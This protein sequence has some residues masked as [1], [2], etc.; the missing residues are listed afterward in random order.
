MHQTS[1]EVIADLLKSSVSAKFRQDLAQ[2]VRC[3]RLLSHTELWQR[4]NDHCNSVANLVL[5][6]TG[7]V[8][9]WVIDGLG[10]ESHSR[11]RPAEFAA[12]EGGDADA[13]L[14]PL[15]Q[16]LERVLTIIAGISADQ[17]AKR[18]TI[19]GYDVS[20]VDVVYHVGEHFSFHTG[21]I[22]HITKAIRGV[23]LSLY[24]EQGRL[25]GKPGG[26]PYG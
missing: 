3:V 5:H 2:I 15:E 17:L 18:Y 8:T 26:Q 23:D 21:Q 10:G 1:A 6:L 11:N 12:R 16:S 25:R 13:I 9:Q 19:Q 22:V 20:G 4:A 7:N 14:P 24:D